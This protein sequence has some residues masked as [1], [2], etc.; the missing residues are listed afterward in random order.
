MSPTSGPYRVVALVLALLMFTTSVSFALDMHYCGGRLKS[1]GF[2]HQAKA[3]TGEMDTSVK[4]ACRHTAKTAHCPAPSFQK[5]KCCQNRTVHVESVQ[6]LAVQG[7]NATISRPLQQ[8]V[9]AFVQVFFTLPVEPSRQS[10]PVEQYRPPL[11]PRDIPV[12]TQSFL[13]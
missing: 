6:D 4:P 7:S 1:V 13:L 2:F 12:L 8:F 3:C 9:A 10:I 11:I 5:K